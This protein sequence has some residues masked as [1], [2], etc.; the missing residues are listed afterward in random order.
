MPTP[1]DN[2]APNNQRKSLGTLLIDANTI[3]YLACPVP[4][5]FR[6][7]G[8]RGRYEHEPLWIDLLPLLAEIGFDVVIP[9]MVSCEAGRVTKE[10]KNYDKLFPTSDMSRISQHRSGFLRNVGLGNFGPNI[11]IVAPF[12]ND[13]TKSAKFVRNIRDA[14]DVHELNTTANIRRG[15]STALKETAG[16]WRLSDIKSAQ[17]ERAKIQN[18]GEEAAY[19]WVLKEKNLSLPVIAISNDKEFCFR[20]GDALKDRGKKEPNIHL[21]LQGLIRAA[22]DMELMPLINARHAS[23]HTCV[24]TIDDSKRKEDASLWND[25]TLLTN[26]KLG[27]NILHEVDSGYNPQNAAKTSGAFRELLKSHRHAIQEMACP[28]QIPVKKTSPDNTL[29]LNK[30]GNHRYANNNGSNGGHSRQ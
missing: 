14:L 15:P 18:L 7:P 17:E 12:E 10:G 20:V 29:R 6:T 26:P 1:A 3:F 27:L 19:Q 2:P 16:R 25:P 4:S 28:E 5:E 13:Q 24:N 23:Y 21:N 11:R 22:C 9:E 8:M 30:F